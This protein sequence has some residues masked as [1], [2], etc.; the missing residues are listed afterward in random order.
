MGCSNKPQR[1]LSVCRSIPVL[2]SWRIRPE[3]TSMQGGT[4]RQSIAAR[5][6]NDAQEHC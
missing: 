6:A 3:R 5:R 1:P 2:S 4:L